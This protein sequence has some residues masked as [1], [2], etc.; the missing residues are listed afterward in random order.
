MAKYEAQNLYQQSKISM[1]S[2]KSRKHG[3][4]S[5]NIKQNHLSMYVAALAISAGGWRKRS[6]WHQ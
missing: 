3:C 1:T 5:N 6:R 4:R 2:M